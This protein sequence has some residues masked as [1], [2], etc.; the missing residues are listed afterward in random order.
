MKTLEELRLIAGARLVHYKARIE[1]SKSSTIKERYRGK[2]LG[3]LFFAKELG[4]F[5]EEECSKLY[6][7]IMFGEEREVMI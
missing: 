1:R 3:V 5:T 7:E 6:D 4:C 2:A